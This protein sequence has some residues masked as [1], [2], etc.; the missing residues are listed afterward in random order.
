MTQADSFKALADP[1][2]RAI[3]DRLRASPASV[4]DLTDGLPIS[5]SAVSQ[6]L[7]VLRAAGLVKQERDG[8]R[9]IYSVDGDGF[10]QVRDWITHYE[11]F[12]D[13]KL[14]DLAAH[15]AKGRN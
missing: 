5:Q 8:Q 6:Q 2:R 9:R 13:E 10:A 1:T 14:D 15:L 4:G 11:A 3:L 12:W 7:G